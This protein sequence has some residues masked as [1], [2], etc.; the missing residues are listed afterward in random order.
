[1]FGLD[2]SSGAVLWKKVDLR[3]LENVD[4]DV[5]TEPPFG[6]LRLEVGIG[7]GRNE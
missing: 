1:L 5:L 6:L 3:E 4:V 2:D 7:T